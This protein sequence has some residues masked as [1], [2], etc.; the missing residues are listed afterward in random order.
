MAMEQQQRA[1]SRVSG[2]LKEKK[3]CLRGLR[4]HP[5]GR[6]DERICPHQKEGGRPRHF[7]WQERVNGVRHPHRDRAAKLAVVNVGH[8]EGGNL[9]TNLLHGQFFAENA[10]HVH[11]LVIDT[12]YGVD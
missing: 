4:N 5:D 3:N 9:C 10:G 11:Q 6:L 1:D 7:G 2:S 8:V 12:H